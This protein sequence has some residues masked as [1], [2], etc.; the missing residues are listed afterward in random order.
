M[1]LGQQLTPSVHSSLSTLGFKSRCWRQHEDLLG[2][3]VLH[4]NRQSQIRLSP[5]KTCVDVLTAAQSLSHS[6]PCIHMQLDLQE[7]RKHGHESS[8]AAMHASGSSRSC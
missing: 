1:L 7:G 5:M 6:A 8:S 4:L 2:L 3:A